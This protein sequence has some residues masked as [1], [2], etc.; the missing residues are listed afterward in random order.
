[1]TRS[2]HCPILWSSICGIFQ[3]RC[4]LHDTRT[5]DSEIMLQSLLLKLIYVLIST[6]MSL[7]Q[8]AYECVFSSQSYYS[9]AFKR[10]MGM[11]P[12]AYAKNWWSSMIKKQKSTRKCF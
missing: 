12:R 9:Y 10:N 4:A 8:I 6:D 11:P 7:S 5:A 3:R 2:W 1:M